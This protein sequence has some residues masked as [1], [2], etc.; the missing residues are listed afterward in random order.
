ML[1]CSSGVLLIFFFLLTYATVAQETAL[2]GVSNGQDLF[3]QNSFDVEKNRF[4]ITSIK[5]NGVTQPLDYNSSALMVDLASRELGSDIRIE[6]VHGAECTPNV[7]NSHVISKNS[8]FRFVQTMADQLSV[9][10]LTTGESPNSGKITLQKLKL[11]GWVPI[12]V[13]PAKGDMQSNAYSQAVSHYSGENQ[14][15]LIY[16]IDGKKFE[17]EQFSFYSSLD[18]IAYY[19]VEEVDEFLQLSRMT[20][21]QIKDLDGNMMMQGVALDINVS[22]LPYGEYYLIIENR[23]E[24]FYKPRPEKD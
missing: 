18:P 14:F 8:G 23:Q 11:A 5:V 15:R 22:S 24:T 12:K 20:D 19:P 7:L 21:Y 6:I 9:S 1:R 17:S 3:I 2:V 10:W 4:C 13:V 16:E